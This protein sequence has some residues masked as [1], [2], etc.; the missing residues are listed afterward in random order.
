MGTGL[1]LPWSLLLVGIGGS[2]ALAQTMVAPGS[3]LL[4][5]SATGTAQAMP[6]LLVAELVASVRSADAAQA[7]R[8]LNRTMADAAT[9]AGRTSGVAWRLQGY[10]V[11]RGDE[12]HPGW[13]ARQTLRLQ[14]PDA[15]ALL[16][17]VAQLQASGLIVEGLSWTL[18]PA[19]LQEAKVRASDQALT[20]LQADAAAAART[21]GL[22]VG[23][24]RDVSLNSEEGGVRPMMRMMSASVPTPR[25]TQ[26]SQD[27][28]C[29]ASAEIELRP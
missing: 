21:L 28:S 14:A 1:G 8:Q 6:D 27:V 20:L 26:D 2:G 7:Q 16:A 4:H 5:L 23:T 15:G 24:I 22:K 13:T 19:P 12:D 3:T 25:T 17:L 18:S 29:E 10:G 11:D 9:R